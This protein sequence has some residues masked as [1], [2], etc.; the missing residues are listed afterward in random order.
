V[1]ARTVLAALALPAALLAQ[2]PQQQPA[3]ST[4]PQQPGYTLHT[5]VRIVLS[6]VTV[7]DKDGH[8]VHGLPASAFHVTLDNDPR[9]ILSFEEHNYTPTAIEATPQPADGSFTNEF[10]LHLPPVLNIVVLD[11]SSMGITGQMD[12]AYQFKQFL[13]Q[14]PAEKPLAIF[15][16]VGEHLV[17]FQNFTADHTLLQAAAD[18]IMPRLPIPHDHYNDL[19]L[20]FELAQNLT[21]I[22]GHKNIL[23]FTNGGQIL[24]AQDP[25][26]SQA[27]DAL[28][29][30]YD[31]LEAARISLYPIDTRGPVPD[32]TGMVAMQHI[33]MND[34]AKNTGGQAIY[35]RNF[36]DQEAHEILRRDSSFYTLTASPRDFQPDNKWHKI[37]ITVEPHDYT[38]SYRRGYFADGHNIAP[39][40]AVKPEQHRGLLLTG[41]KTVDASS[42]LHSQPIIFTAS[43]VPAT[44]PTVNSD[45]PDF[46][47]LHPLTPPKHGRVSYLI[48]YTLPPGV[49]LPLML[50]GH[51]HIGFEVAAI[52]FNQLGEPIA[53]NGQ[54][55]RLSFSVDNPTQP[56]RIE[57]QIDLKKG[58]NF[59]SL[60]VWDT[61]TGRLGSLQFPFTVK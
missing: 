54:R 60:A 8:I 1:I 35:N 5:N 41:G 29:V 33:Q 16:R 47:R 28:R 11:V 45:D 24:D 25:N 58:D 34:Y 19:Q 53:S 37:Q 27:I 39:P 13:T 36:I 51:P 52:S 17:L 44:Q 22:P 57:Q 2:A 21:Q 15:A 23:W 3:P 31:Q 4:S 26:Q 6:D 43:V 38:L 10:L 48:R 32:P 50:N 42:D 12:L 59:I 46:T 9:P 49:F 40:V 61:S 55:V 56:I 20:L 18:R 30:I 7:T 14:L